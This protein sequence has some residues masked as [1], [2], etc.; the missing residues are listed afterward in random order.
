MLPA[1]EERAGAGPEHEPCG[2]GNRDQRYWRIWKG[3][4]VKALL[5]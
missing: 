2:K 1:D 3:L 4:T 5:I